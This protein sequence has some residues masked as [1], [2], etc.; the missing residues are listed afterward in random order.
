MKIRHLIAGLAL[1]IAPAL[2]HASDPTPITDVNQDISATVPD[3][4]TVELGT[5]GAQ[6]FGS[7]FSP[8]A[9]IGTNVTVTTNAN[10]PW[11]ID[12]WHDTDADTHEDSGNLGNLRLCYTATNVD[13]IGTPHALAIVPAGASSDPVTGGSSDAAY[14]SDSSEEVTLG[15]IFHVAYALKLVDPANSEDSADIIPLVALDST[16]SKGAH[17]WVVHYS[18]QSAL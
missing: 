3:F 6:D 9:G 16:A 10:I 14:I 12:V 1:A 8:S 4:T 2:G 7:I 17:T 5:P 15:T 13:S 11:Q 18:F